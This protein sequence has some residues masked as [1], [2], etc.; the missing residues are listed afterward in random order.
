MNVNGFWI[1]QNI[2]TNEYQVMEIQDKRN[3]F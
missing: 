3:V 2:K 1:G